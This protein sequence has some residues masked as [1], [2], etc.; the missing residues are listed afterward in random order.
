MIVE[1]IAKWCKSVRTNGECQSDKDVSMW[2]RRVTSTVWIKNYLPCE[3]AKLQRSDVVLGSLH[4]WKDSG[5]RPERNTAA[6]FS[7]ELKY[8][9]NWELM[10]RHQEGA[11]QALDFAER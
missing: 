11:V 6:A 4:H 8:W 3:F 7:P 10:E 2:N 9:L 5:G 1:F